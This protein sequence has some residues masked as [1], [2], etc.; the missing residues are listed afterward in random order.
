M[1]QAVRFPLARKVTAI[2]ALFGCCVAL[3]DVDPA[4]F[5]AELRALEWREVGPFRGGRS[6][7]AT[8]IASDRDTYYFGATG[9]G[10]WKTSD[11]GESWDN[12]SDGFFGGSIGAVAVSEWDPNVVYVGTGE[13]TV[14]GNVSPGNGV[15]K[16]VDAG[17]TWQPMGLEDSQHISRIRVHPRNPDVAYAAV[18]GHLFGPNEQRGVFR[19]KN[20]GESWERVLHVSDEVGAVELVMDHTNPRILYTSFWRVKSTPYSLESGGPGSGIYKSVDGG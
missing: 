14:R 16:S 8:G 9:G 18:M 6:S 2:L 15:W 12:V 5:P 10:V 19:T 1:N 17:E 4:T 20:G 11:G 13:K 7:A 3:A